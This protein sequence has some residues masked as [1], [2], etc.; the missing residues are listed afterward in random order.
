MVK[1]Y[2]HNYYSHRRYYMIYEYARVST[3]GQAIDGNS[4]DDQRIKLSEAGATIISEDSFTGAKTD[5]PEL[6]ELKDSLKP[7]DTVIVTK[8]DRLAKSASKGAE[9]VNIWL[10]DGITV[11]ILNMGL[12]N[13][14]PTGKLIMQI[15]FAFVKFERDMIVERT[16]E[17]KALAKL[18]P[19][20]KE[21]RSQK[22]DAEK[23][24]YAL[25]LLEKESCSKVSKITGIS[26]ST[27]TRVK[28][29]KKYE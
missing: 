25:K 17:G 27:L 28:R 10:K 26:V 3:K 4:L 9:L 11:H 7:G 19:D 24:E 18:S 2:D 5:C 1:T 22:Y 16:Q 13:D 12:I 8:L 15:M 29:K 21:G 14:T 23:I 6:D 20:F